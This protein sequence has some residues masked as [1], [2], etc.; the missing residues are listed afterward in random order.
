MNNEQMKKTAIKAGIFG[1]LSIAV[2]LQRAATKHILITD[3]AGTHVDNEG[4][5]YSYNILIDQ[6]AS[7]GLVGKLVIPLSK[8]VSSDDIVLEDRYID[9][10]LKIYIDSREEGFYLNNAIITD[11]NILK[12]AV[13]ITENDSGSVCLDFVLNDLYASSSTL[14]ENSTIEVEFSKPSEMYDHT[15]VFDPAGAEGYEI[16]SAIDVALELKEIA[17]KDENSNLKIYFTSLGTGAVTDEKKC[18]LIKETAADLV[19][20]LNSKISGGQGVNNV[21]AYYN[22]QFFLRG[23]NNAEFADMIE[24]NVATSMG[25]VASGVYEA[26]ED[27]LLGNIAVPAAR[28]CVEYE[29]GS[30][31]KKVAKGLYEAI[32]QALYAED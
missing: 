26:D 5:S 4:T 7:K 17:A 29:N 23:L 18:E 2:M 31:D 13:C 9:H 6:N 32:I 25:A 12:S 30:D 16:A 24:R 14:T 22:S 8:T 21:S 28:I 19:I 27:K 15:V 20:S 1:L 11:L 3:A 10:E